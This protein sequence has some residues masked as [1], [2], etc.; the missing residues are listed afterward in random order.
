MDKIIISEL[1]RTLILLGADRTLLGTVNSWKK[2]LPDDMVLSEIRHWN[3]IAA[4]KIHHRIED[5]Q[6]EP[7]E[8]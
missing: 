2:S 6:V 4:E 3:E 5:Y 7:D 8:K 1:H